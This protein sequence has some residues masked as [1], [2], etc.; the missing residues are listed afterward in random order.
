M[1]QFE[2]QL[3]SDLHRYLLSIDEVDRQLPDCPDVEEKWESIATAYIPDGAREFADYPV[4]SLGWM[5]YIGM[6]VAKMWDTEWEIYSRIDNHYAY[7]RDKRGYNKMDDYIREEVL[8]LHGSDNA[9][10]ERITGECASRV[11][12]ALMHLHI[13]PGTKEA[14]Y[15]YVTCLHEMYCMGIAVQLKRMGYHMTKIANQY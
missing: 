9:K 8:Y 14:F 5:M 1:H 3:R 6:A 13:E 4:V 15:A 2:M 10:T 7:I 12:N 11:Y